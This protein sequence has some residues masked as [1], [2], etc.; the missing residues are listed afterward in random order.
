MVGPLA[1]V[2]ALVVGG[3][4]HLT[5]PL[6][7]RDRLFIEDDNA[8][9]FLTELVASDAV[10]GA[11]ALSTCDRV[12]I[13]AVGGKS[14]TV[15]DAVRHAL[16]T[17][18]GEERRG[19]FDDAYYTLTGED[20]ARHLFRVAASLESQV[21][22]EPQVLGQ[23][24]AAHR[25]AR[26]AGCVPATLENVLQM[27]Y[28]AAKRV[29]TETAIADRPVSIA[30][31]AAQTARDVHGDLSVRRGLLIGDGDMGQAIAE[32]LLR[33]GLGTMYVTH[34][35]ADRARSLAR[36]MEAHTV[37]FETFMPTLASADIV[38]SA[39]GRR[40]FAITDGMVRRALSDRRRR[41]ILLIDLSLPGDIEPAVNR[42]DDA[43]LFDLSDLDAMATE[44]AHSRESEVPKATALIEEELV[45]FARSDVER[46]AVPALVR[47]RRHVEALRE[48]ALVEAGDDAEKA[49]RLL[50][51]RLLHQ[52]SVRLRELAGG[53]DVGS[54][55]DAER[56]LDRLFGN[57]GEDT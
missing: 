52:P 24:K 16:Q 17:R 39:Y 50:A 23:V 29:R 48:A 44:G 54:F 27:A 8:V 25:M 28:A 41:P 4:S 30:S 11:V 32:Q 3:V 53:D 14:E 18:L 36:R 34:P 26:G 56:L 10:S 19:A 43:Y 49:T 51:N 38:V 37:P 40:D 2:P 22:G 55:A 35:F 45:A 20:A 15:C 47:L 9:A 7:L 1:A 31:A 42:L 46:T 5:A 21:V 12:E 33:R 57:D 6:D 13:V